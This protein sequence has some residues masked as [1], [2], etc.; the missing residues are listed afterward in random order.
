VTLEVQNAGRQAVTARL[1][2]GIGLGG[3][4]RAETTI[5]YDADRP[6]VQGRTIEWL[7]LAAEL[8]PG[9]YRIVLRLRDAESGREVVRERVVTVRQN[10]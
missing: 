8:K 2:R 4:R 7:E 3:E 10:T 1:L 6:L 5:Q 9:D